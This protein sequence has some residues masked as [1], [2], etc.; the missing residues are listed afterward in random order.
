MLSVK[1]ECPENLSHATTKITRVNWIS[2]IHN[3]KLKIEQI[4]KSKIKKWR[5]IGA[6]EYRRRSWC[7]CSMHRQ[8][9]ETPS[10]KIRHKNG[11]V[12]KYS[13]IIL[14]PASVQKEIRKRTWGIQGGYKFEKCRNFELISE[15]FK[16]N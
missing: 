1:G 8:G 10:L 7:R 3:E 11:T 12:T 2:K 9:C 13:N 4:W 5:R 15:S 6:K 14:L 16:F